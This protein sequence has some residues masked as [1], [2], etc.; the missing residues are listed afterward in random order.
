VLLHLEEMNVIACN[1][2]QTRDRLVGKDTIKNS[3]TYDVHT[4]SISDTGVSPVLFSPTL[5]S[6]RK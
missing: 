6:V 4:S 1:C 5:I 2:E 3:S